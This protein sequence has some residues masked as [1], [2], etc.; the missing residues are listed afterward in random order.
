[1][2][3]GVRKG[4]PT[5]LWE[6]EGSTTKGTKGW[7]CGGTVH[8]P[9]RAGAAGPG[10]AAAESGLFTGSNSGPQGRHRRVSEFL[11]FVDGASPCPGL[12]IRVNGVGKSDCSASVL[13]KQRDRKSVVSG[14]SV[15]VQVDHG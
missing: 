13:G 1:M 6:A 7:L 4:F 5:D 14:R 15:S 3:H 2:S 10:R 12:R 11:P 9:C 8:P